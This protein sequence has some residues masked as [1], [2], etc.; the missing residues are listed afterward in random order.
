MPGIV[1]RILHML[2]DLFF[3]A[4]TGIIMTPIL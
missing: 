4:V 2:T 3:I 1:L